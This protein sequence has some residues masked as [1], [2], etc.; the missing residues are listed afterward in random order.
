VKKS[1]I[2]IKYLI[3]S[4]C[5]GQMI[6]VGARTGATLFFMP[7]PHQLV[8]AQVLAPAPTPIHSKNI[9]KNQKFYIN[10]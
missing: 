9:V 1:K 10:F 8:A 4:L 2:D 7:E 6:G 3:F 5:L